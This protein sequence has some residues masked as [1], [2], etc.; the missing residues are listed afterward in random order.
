[1]SAPVGVECPEIR[2][3]LLICF[4]LYVKLPSLRSNQA[5]DS[6]RPSVAKEIRKISKVAARQKLKSPMEIHVDSVDANI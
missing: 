5:L 4:C 1:M 3:T 6:L 2:C